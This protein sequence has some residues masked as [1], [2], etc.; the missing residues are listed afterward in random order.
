MKKQT[1]HGFFS[2]SEWGLCKNKKRNKKPFREAFKHLNR[3]NDLGV[4]YELHS[5][6]V[7][8]PDELYKLLGRRNSSWQKQIQIPNRAN[9]R[10]YLLSGASAPTNILQLPFVIK[11]LSADSEDI[12]M[13]FVQTIDEGSR[14]FFDLY[15]YSLD[16]ALIQFPARK[17]TVM[18]KFAFLHSNIT[19]ENK[20]KI[21][22]DAQQCNIRILIATS[23]AGAGVNLPISV[24]LGW[25]LD[26]EPSGIVQAGGRTARGSG[27]GHVVWVH[28]PSLH[29][30]RVPATSSV[31]DLLKGG[32]LRACQN[33]WF[34]H[35]KAS[36]PEPQPEPHNCCS[37][38]MEKCLQ[39]SECGLCS[40]FLNKY[41]SN[42]YKVVDR[43]PAIAV[44]S[45]FL[46]SLR[47]PSE[48]PIYSE[49]SL[50]KNIIDYL[51]DSPDDIDDYLEIFSLGTELTKE[52][53]HFISSELIS[54]VSSADIPEESIETL[55]DPSTSS[56]SSSLSE[57]DVE[58]FDDSE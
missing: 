37:V 17:S 21:I 12:M 56:D 47:R 5:A 58:Y 30:Q 39:T 20:K 11:F 36:V 29:G 35:G 26:R 41:M 10:Y 48:C 19:E 1:F 3:L 23:S 8:E 49:L 44:L 9:L 57:D 55:E 6:T 45:Q 28:N 42:L 40:S 51:I 4:P 2:F 54:L 43:H 33:N 50:A 27:D 32:C 38:C 18:K 14:I 16:N 22:S 25:G 24:F 34:C 52:I 15:E 13:I 46:K 53:S 7:Q 31:R